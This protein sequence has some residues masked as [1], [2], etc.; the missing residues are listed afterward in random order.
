MH[1]RMGLEGLA[2]GMQHRQKTDVRTQMLWISGNLQQG[3]GSGLKQEA[4]NHSLVLKSQSGQL[5]GQREY[6]MKVFDRQ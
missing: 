4:V 2:K 1:M 5:L 6:H 3:L